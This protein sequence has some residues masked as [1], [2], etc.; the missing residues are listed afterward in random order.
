MT[1]AAPSSV[2]LLG[3]DQASDVLPVAEALAPRHPAQLWMA[4]PLPAGTATNGTPVKNLLAGPL[5]PAPA[6]A[7]SAA[8]PA[9]PYLGS[10]RAQR[11]LAV[12]AAPYLGS[13]V[14]PPP[15]AATD[16][17]FVTRPHT[18]EPAAQPSAATPPP[19]LLADAQ[20]P[21]AEP[22]PAEAAELSSAQPA[23]THTGQPAFVHHEPLQRAETAPGSPAASTEQPPAAAPSF[24]ELPVRSKSNAEPAVSAGENPT[25]AAVSAAELNMRI[26]QYARHA[27]RLAYESEFEVIFAPDWPAWLAGVELRQL[28]RRPLILQVTQLAADQPARPER[29]WMEALERLTLPHADRILVPDEATAARLHRLYRVPTTR[30]QVLPPGSAPQLTAALVLDPHFPA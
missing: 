7:L 10:S 17:A 15:T 18:A 29:G 4:A 28:T 14:P 21:A 3:W 24:A 11:S 6:L 12:P 1:A 23:L 13:S 27:A 8:A 9:F 30:I 26:I 5:P 22:G 2:L 16:D 19:A 20:Q 25:T